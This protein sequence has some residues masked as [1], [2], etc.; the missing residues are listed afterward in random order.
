MHKIELEING[1]KYPCRQTMGA[2]LLFKQ[3]T[4][5]EVTDIKGDI[6]DMCTLLYCC[7]KSACRHDNIEFNLELMDF[8]DSITPENI[9]AWSQVINEQAEDAGIIQAE[10]GEKKS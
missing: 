10:D 9:V 8:A 3:L 4:N 2:M 7:I 5:K 1:K 6:S